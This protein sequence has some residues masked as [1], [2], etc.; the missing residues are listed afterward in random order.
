MSRARAARG[1]VR[2]ANTPI[3]MG[4]LVSAAGAAGTQIIATVTALKRV[5]TPTVKS[6]EY[7]R[8][9]MLPPFYEGISWLCCPYHTLSCGAC[10]ALAAA[11]LRLTLQ[12]DG[13][14]W[15]G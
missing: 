11:V 8:W 12:P 1:P 2:G 6:R 5:K 3:L 7:L 9:C 13:V 15:G 4:A 14:R 10:P